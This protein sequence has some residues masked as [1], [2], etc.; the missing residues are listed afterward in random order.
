MIRAHFTLPSHMYLAQEKIIDRR[1]IASLKIAILHHGLYFEGQL[2][3]ANCL[4]EYFLY[5][6]V[7]SFWAEKNW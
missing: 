4:F 1:N 6:L 5:K 2:N 3:N 7:H